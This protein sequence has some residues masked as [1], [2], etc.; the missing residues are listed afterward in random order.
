MLL[1][2]PDQVNKQILKAMRLVFQLNAV[3]GRLAK[4][5]PVSHKMPERFLSIEKR[6][7]SISTELSKLF[8]DITGLYSDDF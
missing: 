2:P 1:L 8:E 4:K 3:V 6:L 7:F 5:G